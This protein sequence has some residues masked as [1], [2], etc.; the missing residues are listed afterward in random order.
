M[1]KL[2][3]AESDV[4]HD[5]FFADAADT[6]CAG[7]MAAVA[8]VDNNAIDFEAKCA[9]ERCF[10]GGGGRSGDGG[11]ARGFGCGC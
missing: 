8:G 1:E 2:A 10:T 5:V 7:I 11:M 6:E 9:N 4:E 3:E